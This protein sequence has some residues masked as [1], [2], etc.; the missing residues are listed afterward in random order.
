[1]L[2]YADVCWHMLMYAACYAESRDAGTCDYVLYGRA[3]ELCVDQLQLLHS[4]VLQ[5]L[6]SLSAL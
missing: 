6:H 2:T 4:P 3:T 1:M 5:L